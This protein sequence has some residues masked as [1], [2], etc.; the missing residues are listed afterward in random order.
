MKVFILAVSVMLITGL[1]VVLAGWYVGKLCGDLTVYLKGL[2]E[3]KDLKTFGEVYGKFEERWYGSVRL[4][5]VIVGT[6]SVEAVE[7]GFL[8][9]GMRYIGGDMSGYLAA[10]EQLIYQL[11]CLREGE[12]LSWETVL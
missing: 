8:E 2:P 9:L 12:K 3:E 7:K 4:L 1:V 5:K 6:G 11:Q 10:R